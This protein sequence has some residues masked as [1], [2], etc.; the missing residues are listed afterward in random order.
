VLNQNIAIIVSIASAIVA[1][2]SLGWNIY[3]D[4]ILK[5]RL[6][7][8]IAVVNVLKHGEDISPPYLN[9]TVT[10]F[11]PGVVTVSTVQLRAWSL[12]RR[13]TRRT[14]FAIVM[15]DYTN[16]LSAK[17]P[18]KLEVGDKLDLLFPYDEDCFL[19]DKD[20]THVGVYDFFGRVHWAPP[21][22]LRKICD[23]W[24]KDF[25]QRHKH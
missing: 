18:T 2:I 9:L 24:S 17:L 19:K 23:K 1:S 6:K 8:S 11:G 20:F 3:R 10:N 5:A 7:V 25:P 4:I 14:K 21:D 12:W 15:H 16:P 22:Q 13:L